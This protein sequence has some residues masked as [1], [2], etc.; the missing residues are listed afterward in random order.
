MYTVFS[1]SSSFFVDSGPGT[2]VVL[3]CPAG[4][5]SRLPSGANVS[6]RK[7]DVKVSL[8]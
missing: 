8:A 4:V 2:V 3:Y 1:T 6:L 7:K 5:K